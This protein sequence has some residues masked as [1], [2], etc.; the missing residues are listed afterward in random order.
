MTVSKRIN[1]IFHNWDKEANRAMRHPDYMLIRE[2]EMVTV[3]DHIE[4]LDQANKDGCDVHN[5]WTII[6]ENDYASELRWE[7]GNEVVTHDLC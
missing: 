2:F 6:N 3:N 4:K 1:E 5:R 7:E